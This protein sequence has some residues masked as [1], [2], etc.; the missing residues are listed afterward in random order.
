MVTMHFHIAKMS[1][2][3]NVFFLIRGGGGGW[4]VGRGAGKNL[5]PMKNCHGGERYVK[6]SN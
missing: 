3:R 2:L 4:G 5:S 6:L 1:L